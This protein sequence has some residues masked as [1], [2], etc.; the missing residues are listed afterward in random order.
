M[1]AGEFAPLFNHYKLFSFVTLGA[2]L[3]LM[4]CK[5]EDLRAVDR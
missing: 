5:P 1:I 4:R 3:L 2:I